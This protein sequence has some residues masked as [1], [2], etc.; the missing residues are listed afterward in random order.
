MKDLL[1]ES[2]NLQQAYITFFHIEKAKFDG[3]VALLAYVTI[4]DHMTF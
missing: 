1:H 2:N 3:I 4:S